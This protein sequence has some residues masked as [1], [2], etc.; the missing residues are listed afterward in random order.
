VRFGSRDSV[1]L[2]VEFARHGSILLVKLQATGQEPLQRLEDNAAYLDFVLRTGCVQSRRYEEPGH[3][4]R[5]G[6]E[7]LGQALH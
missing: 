7:R 1:W 4:D 3:L 5:H 6:D 2:E